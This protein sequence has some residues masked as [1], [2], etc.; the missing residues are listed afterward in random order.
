MEEQG[1]PGQESGGA[2][3]QGQSSDKVEGETTDK[4]KEQEQPTEANSDVSSDK[5]NTPS[6]ENTKESKPQEQQTENTEAKSDAKEN[7]NTNKNTIFT[8]EAK[9][10]ALAK[11]RD[12]LNRLNAGFDPEIA[13]LA[14]QVGG[15]YVESGIRKFADYT[16]KMIGEVGGAIKPYLKTS[17]NNIRDTEGMEEIAKEMDSYSDVMSANIDNILKPKDNV[18]DRP[19]SSESDSQELTD[20][21]QPDEDTIQSKRGTSGHSGRGS[22]TGTGRSWGGR[23][24][25]KVSSGLFSDFSGEGSDNTSDQ[26]DGTEVSKGNDAGAT[27]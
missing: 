27:G 24:G 6:P 4:A 7:A 15:Y 2:L 5:T 13:F 14:M 3:G 19:G 8:E 1:D 12:K 9:N 21:I 23:T 10:E 25:G 17:Y 26:Q 16:R 22:K 20:E 11:L 18:F